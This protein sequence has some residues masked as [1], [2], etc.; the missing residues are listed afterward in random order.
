[1][2]K[3]RFILFFLLLV[4]FIFSYAQNEDKEITLDSSIFDIDVRLFDEYL[5]EHP[6][7]MLKNRSKVECTRDFR[8]SNVLHYTPQ[9]D[10]LPY[11]MVM[12]D[13]LMY[14]SLRQELK[15]YSED[16]HAIYGYGILVDTVANGSPVQI[17]NLIKNY[18]D[19]LS[20][21]GVLFVGD[22]AEAYF[23]T[24]NDHD[25]IGKYR[26][27]P[28]DLYYMDM[29]G[30]W[31]DTDLNGIYDSHMGNCSPELYVGRI[32]TKGMPEL[33]ENDSLKYKALRKWFENVHLYW[34]RASFQGEV[35][36][37]RYTDRN[38]VNSINVNTTEFLNI[39]GKVNTDSISFGGG[40]FS[41]NDYLQRI[42]SNTYRFT[43]LASHSTPVLH[44]FST[45]EYIYPWDILDANSSNLGYNLFCC[46]ACNWEAPSISGYMGGS[47][48]FGNKKTIAVV[49]TTKIGSMEQMEKF[50]K[51]FGSRK[52]IGLSMK[53]WWECIFNTNYSTNTRIWWFYGMT[54]L[55]DPNFYL[56]HEVTDY[57]CEN[58]VL[59]SF[60]QGDNSN[61]VM[62]K[63]AA[64][65]T[66]SNNYVIPQGVHV[67]ADAPKITIQG[68]FVCPQGSSFETR[69]EGCSIVNI[70]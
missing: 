43:Q 50:Y 48:L 61:L 63:A 32:S 27:W 70:N 69:N 4:S 22:I 28:C 21:N 51:S 33:E 18:S 66:L 47:Y 25:S 30:V 24:Q 44:Q 59:T 36:S 54:L 26:V 57:C 15:R 31:A 60:P 8:H 42:M 6:E 39:S 11:F 38:W 29:D 68:R 20:V 12:I 46:S 23:E 1:M 14:D 41:K 34:W 62:R 16:V 65:I 35:K 2:I 55:G 37:L 58:L 45:N 56:R 64:S 40:N 52:S 5:A 53:E 7:Y 49:G 9:N 19:S 13:H 3:R 10:T 67:I 17:K